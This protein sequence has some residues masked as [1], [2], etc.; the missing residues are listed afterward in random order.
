MARISQVQA[1]QRL[2]ELAGTLDPAS[3]ALLRTVLAEHRAALELVAF[4]E[5]HIANLAMSDE[6]TGLKNR[7][8]FMVLAEQAVRMADR[9]R[10][11]LVL[12]FAD[13]DGLKRIND[14]LGHNAGDEAIR[15]AARA[16][17]TSFRTTDVVARLAGDE[18]VALAPECRPE[19]ARAMMERVHAALD[20]LPN[21][22][23]PLSMSI[24]Y[25]VYDPCEEILSVDELL[26]RADAEMYARKRA[27]K[28]TQARTTAKAA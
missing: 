5:Q 8:G 6:L 4:Q 1:I 15:C 3:A 22:P 24:G 21:K 13:L 17:E 26:A 14:S 27:H 11:P 18:M 23:C 16:L 10:R 9:T 28:R 12:F 20:S 25:V 7:R 2:H 19:A